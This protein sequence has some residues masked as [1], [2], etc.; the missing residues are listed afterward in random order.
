MTPTGWAWVAFGAWAVLGAAATLG[1][2]ILG[3]PAL[4]LVGFGVWFVLARPGLR[5][6]AIGAL[7]GAGV[8]LLYVAFVHR[9]GP[10]VLC[11][12]TATAAGCDQYE[13][14]WP[15]LGA[16]V[17]LLTAGLVARARGTR[18]RVVATSNN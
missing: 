9:R 15:W 16:G 14:P 17:V 7:S 6:S 3:V 5:R 8:V 18:P 12:R 1:V 4:V 2:L 10:G 11:W 13:N